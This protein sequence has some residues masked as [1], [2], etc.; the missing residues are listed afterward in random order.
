M[1]IEIS[2]KIELWSGYD[3]SIGIFPWRYKNFVP[4]FFCQCSDGGKGIF[5][6][7]FMKIDNFFIKPPT[8]YSISVKKSYFIMKISNRQQNLN[9]I[10]LL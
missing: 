1:R 9:L 2:A 6:R 10:I 3:S 8:E 5:D 7:V 4:V